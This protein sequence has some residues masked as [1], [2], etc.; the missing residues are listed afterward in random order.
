MIPSLCTVSRVCSFS[1]YLLLY[2]VLT[3]S[4]MLDIRSKTVKWVRS[5]ATNMYLGE[6]DEGLTVVH[7]HFCTVLEFAEPM[8]ELAWA[9]QLVAII[10]LWH[11]FYQMQSP[12]MD[13]G[14]W[15]SFKLEWL[16]FLCTLVTS[17]RFSIPNDL[18]Q[19]IITLFQHVFTSVVIPFRDNVRPLGLKL[20]RCFTLSGVSGRDICL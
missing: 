5:T 2:T 14:F 9:S 1:Y 16:G 13:V 3:S 6:S 19:F 15:T 17:T 11:S 4:Y 18:S 10:L 7:P 20:S 8:D 12:F